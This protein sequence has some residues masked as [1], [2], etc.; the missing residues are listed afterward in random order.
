MDLGRHM[1][2]ILIHYTLHVTENAEL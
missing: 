2:S 1:I